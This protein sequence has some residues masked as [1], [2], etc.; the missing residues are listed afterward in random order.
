MNTAFK[1][2]SIIIPT[3]D[4]G[5]VFK[6]TLEA[7]YRA[8]QGIPSEIL[9]INDSKTSMP[10]IPAEYGDRVKVLNN[11]KSGVAS[12][13]NL[14][15]KNANYSY[16]LFLDD[17]ILIFP[18]NITDLI[19]TIT[20]HPL[21]AIN[22]NWIYPPDLTLQID[23]T[24]F[25]RY[26]ISNGFTSLKGWNTN[27]TWKDS[28][29]FQVDL[30][31]SYFLC[32]SA[33]T[34]KRI[35]GYNEAF[36]RAGAEDFEF[37]TRLKKCGVIGLC[38]PLSTVWHNEADRVDLL[39]WMQRK[40]RAA[41]TRKIAVDLGY[42]EMAINASPLKI[43][44]SKLLYFFRSVLFIALMILPNKKIADKL[45][46]RIVTLLLSIYLYKGYFQKRS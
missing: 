40:E 29:I 10:E 45:Y 16:Y 14:G 34:F 7:A 19:D 26:L 8:S 37:A 12:A 28:E 23:K 31:A 17:D 5:S 20:K 32:M 24:Q 11:P 33:D 9:V 2:L 21:A 41:E 1:G 18:Y 15:A 39:P 4:R 30:L 22:F 38:N 43:Y 42:K 46:F 35:G 44:I 25:G 6:N 3:K 27:L 13:R 36:P